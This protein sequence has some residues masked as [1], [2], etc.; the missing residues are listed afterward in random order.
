MNSRPYC[1]ISG[2]LFCLVAIAHLLRVLFGLTV[3][4]DA[5]AVP[6]VVSWIGFAVPAALAWWAFRL[7]REA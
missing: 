3:N 6:M 2:I 7:A 5:F 1:V 4:I